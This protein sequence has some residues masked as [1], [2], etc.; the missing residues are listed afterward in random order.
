MTHPHAIGDMKFAHTSRTLIL[1]ASLALAISVWPASPARADITASAAV[2]PREISVG[3]GAQLNVTIEGGVNIPAPSIPAVDGLNIGYVGSTQEVQ[4]NNGAVRMAVTH[5]YRII[6]TR[7]GTFKIPELSVKVGD[8]VVKTAPVELKVNRAGRSFA[9][10]NAPSPA[11]AVA[12]APVATTPT[13]AQPQGTPDQ[14][15]MV[16]LGIPKRD[17]FVGELVPVDVKVYLRPG[18]RVTAVKPPIFSSPSFMT[19]KPCTKFDQSLEEIQGE[20]FNVLTWRTTVSALKEGEHSL[21]VRCDYERQVVQRVRGWPFGDDDDDALS[22]FFGTQR[23]EAVSLRSSESTMKIL[24]L[25]ADGKPSDFSGAVGRFEFSAAASA[26][27]VTAGD[28][29]TLKMI[30]AGNGNFDR[31]TEVTLGENRGFKTYKPSVRF[32]PASETGFS[33]LK[34]FEQVIVPQ[35]TDVKEIPPVHFSYFDPE[36]RKYVALASD[37]IAL[38]VLPSK[39]GAAPSPA[40]AALASPAATP[41][42]RDLATGR[43]ELVANKLDLGSVRG[44]GPLTASAWYWGA[45]SVPVAALMLGWWV[46]RRRERLESDPNYARGVSAAKA[47]RAGVAEMDAAL[48]AGDPIL[49]FQSA[50]RVLQERIALN[51]GQRPETITFSETEEHGIHD[52]SVVEGVRK[53]F[54]TADEIAYSGQKFSHEAL[55]QWRQHV[56]RTL[57]LL[58]GKS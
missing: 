55:A 17:V 15:G 57:K 49:F 30:V 2:Q 4:S 41:P 29:L 6:P 36:A 1:I 9:V 40:A 48:K 13:T 31:V 10:P 3:Q 44:M 5:L 8:T 11:A 46:A 33:G 51:S 26:G 22:S 52:A 58:E 43:A 35:T 34:V 54:E 38:R 53:I 21:S 50:R 37:A 12:A 23:Q 28:P 18:Q 45:Q 25:P 20:R 24:P 39:P 32:E 14:N 56:L 47:V 16:Q 19:G 27:E 7:D 42:S